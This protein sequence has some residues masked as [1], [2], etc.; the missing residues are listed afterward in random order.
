M[1]KAV[2]SAS[3]RPDEAFTWVCRFEY[4]KCI[5]DLANSGKSWNSLDAKL[6]TA[7]SKAMHGPYARQVNLLEEKLSKEG[8]ML[9]G[10]QMAFML[11]EFM[12]VHEL[13][14]ALLDID[15]LM[16]VQLRDN[17]LEG[18]LDVWENT[19]T[20]MAEVPKKPTLEIM[21][22]RQMEKCIEFKSVL[23]LYEL[24]VTQGGKPR[25]YDTLTSMVTLTS[26]RKDA[27]R[28]KSNC[29]IVLVAMTAIVI[30]LTEA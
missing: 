29:R 20:G 22:R 5:E 21:F 18:F 16:Q 4:A 26:R 10:M 8:K 30:D 15:D 19:L 6:A 1:K 2:A 14:G 13:E 12:K 25:D 7:L 9:K 3:G 11:K 24:S 27:K 28:T 23:D 17:N